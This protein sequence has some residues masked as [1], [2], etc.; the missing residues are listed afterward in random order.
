[1]P[2]FRHHKFPLT[3]P[4]QIF[5]SLTILGFQIFR[6]SC[7]SVI[8]ATET[9]GSGEAPSPTLS[10]TTWHADDYLK[11]VNGGGDKKTGLVFVKRSAECSQDMN[12]LCVNANVWS[13][14]DSYTAV[15][16]PHSS[17]PSPTHTHI[18]TCLQHVL[19]IDDSMQFCLSPMVKVGFKRWQSSYY[20]TSGHT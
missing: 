15:M 7:N 1:M 18:S 5:Y 9:R 12:Q 10:R 6:T 13:E 20:L 19:L 2:F 3:F 4:R 8:K 11:P 14:I 16:S 17:R